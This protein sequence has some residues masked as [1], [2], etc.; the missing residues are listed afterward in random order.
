MLNVRQGIL[1]TTKT[2]ALLG[3]QRVRHQFPHPD[4]LRGNEVRV[5]HMFGSWPVMIP[6]GRASL[7]YI[8]LGCAKDT[9]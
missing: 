5:E 8:S 1:T 2:N 6:P 9:V 7:F 4:L 3:F